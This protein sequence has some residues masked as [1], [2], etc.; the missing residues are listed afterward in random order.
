MRLKAGLALALLALPAPAMAQQPA[1]LTKHWDETPGARSVP[2]GGQT[3]VNHGLVAV[4]RLSA[5]TRDFRG[6]TLG[7]FSGMALTAWRRNP[8][9]SYSGGLLTL[10][11]RGPGNVGPIGESTDYADRVHSHRLTL[12]GAKL[13]ITPTG[14]FLLRDAMGQPFI[15]KDPG[16]NVVNRRGVAYP[17]LNTGRGAGRL[18]L[19]PES[20]AR[21]PDGRFYVSDEYTAGIYLFDRSGRQVGAIPA[22][23]ALLPMTDGRLNFNSTKP[24]TTGRR[25]NQ[26]LEAV[27]VSPDGTR[28]MTMLQSA[29]MQDSTGTGGEARRNTRVLIYDISRTRSPRRPIGH[30]VLQ[31]PVLREAGDGGPADAAAAQ[32]EMVALN[33]GQFLVLSRDGLGRGKGSP[34]PPVFKSVLLADIAGATNLAGTDFEVGVKPVA[35]DGRLVAGILPVRQVELVNLLN[36]VQLARVGMNLETAPSTPA[37]LSEKWEALALAPMLD[38]AAPHDVLLFVGNDNDFETAN[39]RVNGVDFD[40]S[41]TGKDGSGVGDNDSVILVYRLTLPTFGPPRPPRD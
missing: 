23:P 6:E 35:L 21:L 32:S 40:A 12:K 1:N 5:R 13:E 38:K 3:Y 17:S 22:V 37:S 9:G 18:S 8:D 26:G 11:D 20:I 28:L 10:P 31:L 2:F 39:G 29:A 24:P 34:R 16:D 19:D 27:S 7:S 41:L 25:N 36:P 14:G 4:G 15:G 33:D 30:Y